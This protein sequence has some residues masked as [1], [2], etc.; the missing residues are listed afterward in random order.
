M[1][2][3][4][5]IKIIAVSILSLIVLCELGYIV[6]RNIFDSSPDIRSGIAGA[7]TD[8]GITV[9]IN[10]EE[11][12][13]YKINGSGNNFQQTISLIS[14]LPYQIRTNHTVFHVTAITV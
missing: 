1:T 4:K 5:S 7:V 8:S 2:R 3:N 10:N 12:P 9:K 14:V 11:I 6:K 13:S